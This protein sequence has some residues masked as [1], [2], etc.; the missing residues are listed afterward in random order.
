MHR[1]LF[2]RE[3][4][5]RRKK[6]KMELGWDRFEE[7]YV[8]RIRGEIT[9]RP[10][11]HNF[12]KFLTIIVARAP[13]H[14]SHEGEGNGCILTCALVSARKKRCN[15]S[16]EM[17]PY[18]DFLPRAKCKIF[19]E[20]CFAAGLAEAS[21]SLTNSFTRQPRPDWPSRLPNVNGKR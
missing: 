20:P 6:S 12:P 11:R 3:E 4:K 16:P 9:C 5:R 2:G 1:R 17:S 10:Q 18:I 8:R 14:P 19:A 13:I 21:L 7:Y 15:S